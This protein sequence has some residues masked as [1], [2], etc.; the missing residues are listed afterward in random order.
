ML[1]TFWTEIHKKAPSSSKLIEQ[2]GFLTYCLTDNAIVIGT[3][4]Q[5]RMQKHLFTNL[6]SPLRDW[7]HSYSL[8]VI[9]TLYRLFL[10][11]SHTCPCRLPCCSLFYLLL[12]RCHSYLIALL[13]LECTLSARFLTAAFMKGKKMGLKGLS[14]LQKK[15][16]M[17]TVSLSQPWP[18]IQC[19][20]CVPYSKRIVN[21]REWFEKST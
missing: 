10:S 12:N 7:Y 8:I 14:I 4:I 6:K 16:E 17:E 13:H 21:S 15:T 3:S 20:K 5:K 18:C 9:S 19:V 1:I 2:L 11:H